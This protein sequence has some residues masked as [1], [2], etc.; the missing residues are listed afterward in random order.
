MD[1]LK[2]GGASK[3]DLYV[4]DLGQGPMVVK[5]FAAKPWWGRLLGRFLIRREIRAY[6]WLGDT[7][8]VPRL[9]G[10]VDPYAVALEKIEGVMLFP[11]VS[12]RDDGEILLP[13]IRALIDRFHSRG[14]AHLDLN[15]ENLM[16]RADDEIIAIDLAGG[17]W[18]RPGGLWH[19]LLFRLF[20]T[21]DE[22]AYLK[23][24]ARLTHGGL[25]PDEEQRFRRL[26]FVRSLWPFNRPKPRKKG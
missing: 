12:H 5:D 8:G 23:W 26:R 4:V 10:R 21:A 24:K 20:A 13:K 9:I 14:F 15:R 3:A 1:V 16:R 17:A 19:R 6:R 7:P 18:F 22:T 11:A 25:D 2:S